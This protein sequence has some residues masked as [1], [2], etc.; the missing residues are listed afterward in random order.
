MPTASKSFIED[1]DD[2]EINLND[3]SLDSIEEE[4]KVETKKGFFSKFTSSLTGIFTGKELTEDDLEPIMKIFIDNLMEKNVARE[5]AENLCTSLQK[6]LLK[7]KTQSFTSIKA[8]V[9]EALKENIYKIL[10]PK[11][12]YDLLKFA[13]ANKNRSEPYK[14]VFIGVNG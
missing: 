5:I 9:K 6:N 10:T 7:T 12:E 1:K 3:R 8:T 13:L 2:D 4:E 14:I 11:Q